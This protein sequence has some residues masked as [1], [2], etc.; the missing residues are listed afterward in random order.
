MTGI[1]K[2]ITFDEFQKVYQVEKNKKYKLAYLLGFGSGLRLSEIIGYKRKIGKAI[3][4]LISE[5]VNLQTHQIKIVD[6][7]GGLYG[8]D[9][10]RITI[11]PPIL[12]DS[13]LQLLPL[14]NKKGELLSRRTLQDAF[15]RVCKKV[16]GKNLH[17]HTL[18][19]G[20]GNYT[21]NVLKIPLPI[22]QAM[23]GHSRLDTTGIYTKVNPEFAIKT[24]WESMM[25]EE[26]NKIIRNSK[27]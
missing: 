3:P 24:A 20:F 17:F 23:M 27:W 14:T 18:R 15:K 21:A 9:K 4:P 16:L 10:W 26:N 7:K 12:K 25:G 2:Y 19:H 6:S 22:V 13:H 1:V 8:G 5:N 11:I